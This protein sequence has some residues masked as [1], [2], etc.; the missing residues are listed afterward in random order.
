LD[1][2]SVIEPH[3]TRIDLHMVVAADGGKL[4]FK[5]AGRQL[6]LPR[7]SLHTYLHEESQESGAIRLC[8]MEYSDQRG[9]PTVPLLDAACEQM[10]GVLDAV[11]HSEAW[12][13]TAA[14][15]NIASP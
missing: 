7:P 5:L 15:H 13:K 10:Q 1:N 3:I 14:E 4:H 9:A 8:L 6:Y 11:A 2:I 12:L